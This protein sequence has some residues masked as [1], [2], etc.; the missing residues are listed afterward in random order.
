MKNND[1]LIRLKDAL[2]I[3]NE[4]IIEIF[5][6]GEVEIT[7]KEVKMM[8][9]EVNDEKYDLECDNYKL[10][11]FL[12]GFIIFKR[13]KKENND[14]KPN[15]P[16]LAIKDKRSVNNV[17]LKK[18]KIAF[19]LTA[20]DMIDIFDEAGFTV[21]KGELTPLFRKEGHKHYKKCSDV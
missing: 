21:T 10:E 19:S 17:L 1:L 12:N 13:G 8:L 6:F 3:T 7:D 20:D 14:G 4:E 5:K 11:A 2:S 16:A 15:K 9:T 18:L